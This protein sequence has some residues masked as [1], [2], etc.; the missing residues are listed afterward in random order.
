MRP[1]IITIHLLQTVPFSNLNRD[2]L[3]APKTVTYGGRSRT[4]VS[5]QCWKRATRKHMEAALKDSPGYDRALRTRKPVT[6]LADLLT[7]MGWAREQALL[8]G[9]IVFATYAKADSGDDTAAT[10]TDATATEAK[11]DDAA[12]NDTNSNVLLFLT[13]S[14]YADLAAVADEHK[15][16]FLARKLDRKGGIDKDDKDFK[17]VRKT[18]NDIVREPR[19]LI[20]VFGRM[21]AA[22]PSAN[23]ESAVQVAHAFTVH[24]SA[25]EFDYFTA[26]DDYTHAD[27]SGA[28]HLASAE[29]T[30]GTYYRYANIDLD[31][32]TEHVG[33]TAVARDLAAQFLTSFAQSLPSGK[34]SGTAANTRPDLVIVQVRGDQPL[35]YAAAFEKPVRHHGDGYLQSAVGQLAEHVTL[36]ND[37]Y[38]DDALWTGHLNAVTRD[39]LPFGDQ[40]RGGIPALVA[41]AI[42]H[43]DL[44]A[45][46]DAAA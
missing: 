25:P 8:A 41:A 44:L 9:R 13:D 33:D 24:E 7:G 45:A 1:R 29:F 22:M 4:R 36:I 26:V 30:T 37:A 16:L 46:G 6:I 15:A 31:T 11:A 23:I 40:I 5:S 17:P 19:G 39:P 27:E 42:G 28:G 34:A 20:T 38:G 35:S 21:I 43:T 32:L 10:D 3:G 18:L 2:D 12:D 14:Q